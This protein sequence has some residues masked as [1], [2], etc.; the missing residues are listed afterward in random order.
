[1]V[2]LQL[3]AFFGV[4]VANF[5]FNSTSMVG[6]LSASNDWIA[7]YRLIDDRKIFNNPLSSFRWD[8]I[9]AEAAG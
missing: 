7:S 3:Y 8:Q 1:M 6:T 4:K 5:N 9:G 2:G